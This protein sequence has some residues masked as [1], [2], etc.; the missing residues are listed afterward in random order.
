M[1]N[2][3][4]KKNLNTLKKINPELHEWMQEQEDVPWIQEIQSENE[5]KNILVES[6]SRQHAIYDLKNPGKEA[7]KAT[8]PM[9]LYKDSI[10][11]V[12]GFGLGYLANA[13]L[14]KM[15]KGHRVI[16]IE[17][18]AH[19]I[20]LAL[21]NF[22]FSGP[23]QNGTL[24]VVAPGENEVASV[25]YTLSQSF[26]VSDWRLTFEKFIPFRPGEYMAISKFTSDTLNQILC[27]TGTIAG[28]AGAKIADNDMSCLPYVIRA[29]GVKE[30]EG[31]YKDK[32]AILVS[33]G[34]SLQKNIH[35][36]IDAQDKAIIICVGQAL[37]PLLAYGVRPDFACT[38]DF[39][40]V[41]MGH[42]VG[43][44]GCGIPL[45]TIN[46]TYAPLIKAWKGPKFVAG[47]WVPGFEEMA[48]GILTEKGFIDAGGSVAHMCFGLAKLLKCNPITFMAQDLALGETSHSK[49]A[50]A[51]GDIYVNE[52]GQIAWKIKD[53][54]C[55]LH[56]KD[57][58]G[59]GPAV[60]V[61]GYWGP[62]VLTN[63]G[64]ESFR[65]SFVSMVKQHLAE[66]D[67]EKL[68]KPDE[69]IISK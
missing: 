21:S 25:L 5:Q 23:M 6:G 8:K 45:V 63:L 40:S 4:L 59:M 49:L 56:G 42:F 24:I 7:K 54:R 17:P 12:V 38:V 65:Y 16:V 46:R 69:K 64:L 1:K 62:N 28:D 61:P 51:G 68:E 22:D 32:P 20:R 35:H 27:N 53:Q 44:M 19:V 67:M 11:I 18:I 3:I 29:R 26:V 9:K 58:V 15:D 55:S 66:N 37:R 33:T 10:S 13:I 30:L 43:L 2:K 50:D 60:W 14:E 52:Q 57:A 31:L 47:T 39:G 34:P 48:T 41:N 36:L